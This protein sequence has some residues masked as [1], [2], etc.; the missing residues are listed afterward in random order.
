MAQGDLS[1]QCVQIS[2][3]R[4]K[5]GG[6]RLFSVVS[7]DC[8]RGSEHKMKHRRF[9]LIIREHIFTVRVTEDWNRL[10]REVVECLSLDIFKCCLGMFLGILI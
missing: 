5:K 10:P 2:E 7:S 4:V 1:H 9:C 8:R 3:R 6:A